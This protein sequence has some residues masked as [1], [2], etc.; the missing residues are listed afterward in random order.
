MSE[1][2]PEIKDPN[3]HVRE[4]LRYYCNP[5]NQF[6]FAVILK[7]EWGAGKTFFIKNF[8]SN[9]DGTTPKPLYVSLYG[10][11]SFTQ[12]SRAHR[13]SAALQGRLGFG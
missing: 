6:D 7:G 12:I 1:A 3:E 4:Y 11:P 9:R 2:S 13:E 5:S 10:L 8:I